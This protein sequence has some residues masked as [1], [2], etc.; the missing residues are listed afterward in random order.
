MKK[1]LL[2]LLFLIL[3]IVVLTLSNKCNR[4]L[5]DHITF[6]LREDT[7]KKFLNLGGDTPFTVSEMAQLSIEGIEQLR[8]YYSEYIP[9]F[10]YA[11][12]A[13]ILLFILF[14]FID[15]LI[16]II[17]LIFSGWAEFDNI[18]S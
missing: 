6:K 9:S 12:I 5:A 2:T 13:P 16:A 15:Y 14:C 17:Y 10:F 11:M 18:I 8:L 7:Y 1:V 3:R 4:I